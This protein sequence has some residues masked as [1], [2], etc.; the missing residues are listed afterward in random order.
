MDEYAFI[1]QKRWVRRTQ[2]WLQMKRLDN[3]P[4]T[5]ED[6]GPRLITVVR[7]EMLRLPYFFKYYRSLGVTEFLVVDNASDD[8]TSDFLLSQPDTSVWVTRET[9]T[10]QEAWVD[11]LLRRHGRCGWSVIVDVDEMLVWPGQE[12]FSLRA[13]LD[14]FDSQGFDAM[15][16]LLLDMYPAGALKD[17]AYRAGDPFLSAASWFDPA[18]HKVIDYPYRNCETVWP[19]RYMGGMRERVFGLKDVCLSKFP[20]VRFHRGMFVRQGTH[21][22]EGARIADVRGCLLHFKYLGDFAPRVQYEAVRGEHWNGAIQYKAY[23]RVVGNDPDF[24]LHGSCSVAYEGPEQI[25]RLG[26]MKP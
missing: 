25:I 1:N 19:K 7:N 16:A 4:L 12:S 24:S 14:G 20:L 22:V 21:A 11:A 13:L 10:R 15:H 3:R 26:L 6:D 5:R 17:A 8:G 9:Y 23:A 2:S 18:S